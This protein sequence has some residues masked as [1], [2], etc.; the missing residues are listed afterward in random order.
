MC[1]QTKTQLDA[2]VVRK[3]ASRA[4]R[5]V[6]LGFTLIEIMVAG[7]IA[8]VMMMLALPSFTTFLRN[9]EIRSTADSIA[10]GLRTARTEAIRRNLPVSFTLVGEAGTPSWVVVQLSDKSTIQS[11]SAREVGANT[12]VITR[13]EAA[14]NVAFNGLGRVVPD[15]TNLEQLDIDSVNASGARRLRIL[16]DD[17]RGIRMCDPS[18]ALAALGPKDARA[19]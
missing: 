5:K 17:A 11:Y 4:P 9:A 13:P 1:A 8:S 18:P 2:E 14:V 19:C 16:I 7:V 15:T 10:N 6:P 3:R 12:A